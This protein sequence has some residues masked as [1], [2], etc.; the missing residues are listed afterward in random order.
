MC[1]TGVLVPAAAM[2]ARSR[3]GSCSCKCEIDSRTLHSAK[4]EARDP[5]SGATYDAR[6]CVLV[7]AA[8]TTLCALTD[9]K[10]NSKLR[11]HENA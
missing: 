9:R 11:R 2:L 5:L 3:L 6:T 7:P 8:P 4:S 10:C 1:L